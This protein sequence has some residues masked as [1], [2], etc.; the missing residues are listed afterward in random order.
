MTITVRGLSNKH[1]LLPFLVGIVSLRSMS[2][3]YAMVFLKAVKMIIL[4]KNCDIFL[5]LVKTQI[6][7]TR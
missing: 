7:C 2:M 4:D 1:F 6:V 5:I 3:H